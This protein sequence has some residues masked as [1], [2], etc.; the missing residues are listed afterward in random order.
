M[1]ALLLAAGAAQLPS[2]E[3][4]DAFVF[5]DGRVERVRGVSGERVTWSGIG[6]TTYERS[7]N[8]I[9]PILAWKVA[10]VGGRRDVGEAA[11]RLWPLAPG[12]TARFPAVTIV[13]GK[14]GARRSAAFWKCG[15]GR[16]APVAVPAGTFEAW[17]IQCERYSASTMRLVERVQWDWAPELGHYVRRRVTLYADGTTTEIRLAAALS[18]D[19]ATTRRLRALAAKARAERR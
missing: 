3:P 14:G 2:Y 19:G 1:I 10:G 7:A 8:P 6:R 18:G 4:G 11:R 13:D 9:V 12:K 16:P 15:V 17:P 5:N